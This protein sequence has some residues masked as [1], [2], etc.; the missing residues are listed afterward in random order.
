[1]DLESQVIY[2]AIISSWIML[3]ISF[4]NLISPSNKNRRNVESLLVA[5][6]FM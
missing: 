2:D 5:E 4:L 3:A 6:E 1:M